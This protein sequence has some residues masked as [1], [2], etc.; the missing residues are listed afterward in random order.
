LRDRHLAVPRSAIDA[1]R[2]ELRER[3]FAQQKSWAT[4]KHQRTHSPSDLARAR[5]R[6]A[7]VALTLAGLGVDRLVYALA[8]LSKGI[9]S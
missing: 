5:G 1:A 2:P 3:C 8:D 4:Y 7:V 6:A 9:R